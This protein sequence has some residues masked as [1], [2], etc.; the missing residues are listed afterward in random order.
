MVF[1][2]ICS[3]EP[4]LCDL[5]G[6]SAWRCCQGAVEVRFFG[7]DSSTGK[8]EDRRRSPLGDLQRSWLDQVHSEIVLDAAPGNS[9]SGDGLVTQQ[10]DL[11]LTIV[12]ADC[13]PVLLAGDRAL[14]AVHAGWRGLATSIL[15]RAVGR[16][17]SSPGNITAW[18]GPAIGPCCYEVGEDVARSVCDASSKEI[19][20]MGLRG[21]PH[22]DLVAAARLQ[23]MRTG[24]LAIHSVGVCTRCSPDHLW[25]YR[26]DGPGAGRNMAAIWQR[27]SAEDRVTE[28]GAVIRIED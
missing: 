25:S 7:R 12:T 11:A 28:P 4:E 20:H 1:D 22:L 21:R 18:I 17:Q 6:Y 27:S 3:M 14:G 24:V 13:V 15:P 2:K 19:A 16:I 26:R 8:T 9:G 5:N 10:Q 23:L